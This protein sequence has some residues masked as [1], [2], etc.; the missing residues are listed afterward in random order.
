[1]KKIFGPFK[2]CDKKGKIHY[3]SNHTSF[4]QGFHKEFSE[5]DVLHIACVAGGLRRFGGGEKNA[6]KP[7]I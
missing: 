4:P 3:K 7:K 5:H 2:S 6:R 1:M